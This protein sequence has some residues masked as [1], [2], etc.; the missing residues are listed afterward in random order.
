MK[1]I[2]MI[3][4]GHGG[5]DN[6]AVYSYAEEDDTN[7]SIAYLLR[8][9]LQRRGYVVSM[10]R[11]RD[12][13]VSLSGR[14]DFANEMRVDLFVSIHCDAFHKIT[15]KGMTTHVAFPKCSK[16]SKMIAH[17]I[18]TALSTKFPKHR[19]RG[20]K[21]S[22]FYVLTETKMPAVLIECEF[23]SNPE[24]RKFLREPENQYDLAK[25]ITKGI[26]GSVLGGR[27]YGI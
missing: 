11:E 13:F 15:A 19:N 22:K 20:V 12:E 8:C 4:P 25:A 23:L 3:D 17:S 2:I 21:E 27:Q 26:N 6:G 10:T 5:H 24:T 16:T 1:S 7:L 9:E 14:V 18:Q